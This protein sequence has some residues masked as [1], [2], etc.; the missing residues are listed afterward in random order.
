MPIVACYYSRGT[1]RTRP[2]VGQGSI[3]SSLLLRSFVAWIC[4]PSAGILPCRQCLCATSPVTSILPS[5][6][7]DWHPRHH[8]LVSFFASLQACCSITARI[9]PWG[10]TTLQANVFAALLSRVASLLKTLNAGDAGIETKYRT[11]LQYCYQRYCFNCCY[12][13]IVSFTWPLQMT[14]HFYIISRSHCSKDPA[15]CFGPDY[16]KFALLLLGYTIPSLP[17]LHTTSS[18]TLD[19]PRRTKESYQANIEGRVS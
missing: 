2:I 17:S 8:I 10:P 7:M 14:C 1:A 6:P 12:G 3:L 9:Q 16:H 18:C 15:S 5:G 11:K 4:R 13:G 19:S